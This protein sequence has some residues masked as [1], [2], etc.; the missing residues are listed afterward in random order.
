M[1]CDNISLYGVSQG[2]TLGPLIFYISTLK[3]ILEQPQNI[4]YHIYICDYI[5]IYAASCH[6]NKVMLYTNNIRKWLLNNNLLINSNKTML[7]NISLYNF[8]FP[9]IIFDNILITPSSK[10]KFLGIFVSYNVS[11]SDH[12]SYVNQLII[13]I[14]YYII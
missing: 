13:Y 7:L 8:V 9:N 5:T 4:K 3:Y 6:R 14:I 10:I 11:H 2:P 1:S 12:V